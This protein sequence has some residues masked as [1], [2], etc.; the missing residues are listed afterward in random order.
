MY[1]FSYGATEQSLNVYSNLHCFTIART[2]EKCTLLG[3][4]MV[5][6]KIGDT[7]QIREHTCR[8]QCSHACSARIRGCAVWL[9]WLLLG[10]LA[11]GRVGVSSTTQVAQRAVIWC[12]LQGEMRACVQPKFLQLGLLLGE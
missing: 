9:G 5:G 8:Q 7:M 12:L 3:P 10:M 11:L 2:L 1:Y 4:Q 6:E